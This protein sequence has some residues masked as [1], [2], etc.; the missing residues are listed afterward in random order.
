MNVA[1]AINTDGGTIVGDDGKTVTVD[2]AEAKAGLTRL[3]DALQERRHPG[4]SHHLPGG[5]GPHRRSRPASC[6]S[7]ATGRTSTAWPR[8]TE[9]RRSR[10]P[11]ASH[12][13][14]AS[15]GPGVSSL[16]GHNAAISVYSKHKATAFEFL[17][18]LQSEETQKFFVTQ[19]SLAPVLSALYDDADAERAA[20]VPV[21]P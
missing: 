18:F 15:T 19:G 14:R 3:V 1:E 12:R 7:C 5:A 21:R 16:G 11:S 13:S 20:A 4:G 17:K 2:S 10:T 8:P 9:A 6:C